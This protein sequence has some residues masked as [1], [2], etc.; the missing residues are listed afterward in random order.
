MST[1]DLKLIT[2]DKKEICLSLE[3]DTC[4]GSGSV[5]GQDFECDPCNEC[6]GLGQL[7]MPSGGA[8]LAFLKVF[9]N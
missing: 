9:K 3:C 6:E 8:L 5:C 1:K 4:Q 2:S 7:L